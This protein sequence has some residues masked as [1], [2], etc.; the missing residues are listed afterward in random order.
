[1]ISVDI[2]KKFS[3]LCLRLIIW[4]LSLIIGF[5]SSWAKPSLDALTSDQTSKKVEAEIPKPRV[6]DALKVH[7][8]GVGLGQTFLGSDFKKNGNSEITWD[9]YYNYSA[10][11]TFDYLLNFHST[12]HER[13][14]TMARLSGVAGAIKAKIFNFDNFS[15]V[16][17]GGL[18]F[19]WP[20]VSRDI[21]D[22]RGI[23]ETNSKTVFGYNFGGGVELRLNP[24]FM[25]GVMLHFHN[26]F[27]VKQDIDPDVEGW[28]YKLLLT[29]FYTF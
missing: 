1:L 4:N 18:G 12:T 3:F 6:D 10:S 20:K 24:N 25:T 28:Y 27:D 11:H 23:R 21:K 15:P 22:G 17:F 19:Y 5:N 8:L 14:E 16:G 13:G 2:K 9:L 7:S 26:P 29:V